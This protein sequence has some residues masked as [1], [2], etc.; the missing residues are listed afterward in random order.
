MILFVFIK[1]IHCLGIFSKLRALV[2]I[3]N[4]CL[5]NLVHFILLLVIYVLMF[6]S[7]EF[8]VDPFVFK[9]KRFFENFGERY[10][11]V[12]GESTVI[13]YF[14]DSEGTISW[15]IYFLFTIVVH[16]IMLNLLI[17]LVFDSY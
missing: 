6:A 2:Q 10:R 15:I 4:C 1:G 12:F 7:M 9:D 17:H 5:S 8:V 16:I 13:E 11:S 3:M 14:Y